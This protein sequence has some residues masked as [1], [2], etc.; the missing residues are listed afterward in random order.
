MTFPII[1]YIYLEPEFN[2]DESRLRSTLLDGYVPE[3]RPVINITTVT[4]VDVGLT[5][6]QVMGLVS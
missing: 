1:L 3:A 4:V 5:I 6:I 2:S